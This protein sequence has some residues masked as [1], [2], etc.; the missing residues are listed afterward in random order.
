MA[1]HKQTK[2]SKK[3]DTGLIVF[4]FIQQKIFEILAI[5]VALFGI[6]WIGYLNPFK[7]DHW[8]SANKYIS[9]FCIGGLTL[10]LILCAAMTLFFIG[11]MIYQLCLLNWNW[12][13]KRASK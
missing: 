5:I 4:Y 3:V 10:I 2:K 13:K 1:K 8:A 9:Y 6:G 7:V 12:A 11:I